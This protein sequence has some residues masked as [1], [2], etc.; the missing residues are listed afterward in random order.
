MRT[1]LW[2]TLAVS[3]VLF[4]LAFFIQVHRLRRNP[5]AQPGKLAVAFNWLL[6]IIF[7]GSL[8]GIAWDNFNPSAAGGST[9]SSSSSSSSAVA[10]HKQHVGYKKVSW[11]P[12]E[13]TLDANGEAKATFKVPAGTTVKILGQRT[14]TVYKTIKAKKHDRKVKYSFKYAANY[15]VEITT[16]SGKHEQHVI[17]VK[18]NQSSSSSSSVASSSS[19]SSASQSSAA[20]AAANTNAA[21]NNATAISQS[22]RRPYGGNGGGPVA[23]QSNVGNA[24]A[25]QGGAAQ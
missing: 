8:T 19:S 1:I 5:D 24:T 18:D 20:T 14:R 13:L 22:T 10:P 17:T 6:L 2:I 12:K 4:L 21:R 9:T 25:N 3:A 15:L 11:E 7:I 23:P 16:K